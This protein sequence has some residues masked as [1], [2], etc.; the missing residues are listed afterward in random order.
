V[1]SVLLAWALCGT[2]S[3][4][5]LRAAALSAG[6]VAL[7]ALLAGRQAEM[8]RMLEGWVN[9]NTGSFNRPGLEAFADVLAGELSGLDFAVEREPAT[10][11]W[12]PGRSDVVTGPLLI[13][14]RRAA[15]SD[16]RAPRILL[17]GHYDTV[18]EASSGFQR[19]ER[20]G[21]DGVRAH[22]PGVADMKGGLVVMLEALRAL[23]EAKELER[24]HWVV[25][26]N[27]DEE[28][29]S[30]GSR[31]RIEAE[32]AAADFGLVFESAQ[33]SGAMVRSRRGLGQFHLTVEGVAA[34]A[35]SAHERGRS[36]VL[37][38]ARKIVEVEAITDYARGVTVNVGTIEGG[39]KRNIVPSRAAAWIDVRYD[40]PASGAWIERELQRIADATHVEGTRGALWG[41][42]HRPPKPPSDAVDRL[43]DTHA[44]VLRGMGIEPQPA[45]HSG[46]GTDGS[47]MGAAG[48][49]TLDSMGVT[50]G[51][52]HT[53]GEFIDLRS[54]SERA[55]VAAILLQR[56]IDAKL[57]GAAGEG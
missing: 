48:L 19:F 18:F 23:R 53:N 35:G 34:H 9:Q 44:R 36:A 54:L 8:E 41:R 37:A 47:L 45:L 27:A 3:G 49:P 29:G 11:L 10:P 33:D 51:R 4:A 32:A 39:T 7:R 2:P 50:G 14:R 16:R 55:A 38:L 26:L 22:G 31:E 46:G 28:I 43:L 17:V 6:E 20:R 30:L 5:D 25:V 13:G 15:P 21:P 42:L 40:E 12:L 52:A 24:A 56:L 1:L 57:Y